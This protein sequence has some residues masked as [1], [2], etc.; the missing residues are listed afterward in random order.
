MKIPLWSFWHGKFWFRK[1]KWY[2][3]GHL[4]ISRDPFISDQIPSV[5]TKY[6]T[7]SP[8]NLGGSSAHTFTPAWNHKLRSS[9]VQRFY[10]VS[11]KSPLRHVEILLFGDDVMVLAHV[12]KF[13]WHFRETNKTEPNSQIR[14]WKTTHTATLLSSFIIIPFIID[15]KLAW[16]FQDKCLIDYLQHKRSLGILVCSLSSPDYRKQWSWPEEMSL[17]LALTPPGGGNLLQHWQWEA[18]A[19][20]WP[21]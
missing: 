8:F 4:P 1:V 3:Q 13:L 17:S 11:L 10:R 2:A 9:I 14:V 6:R 20:K 18:E 7:S 19:R 5:L 12:V 16:I 15:S 21:T